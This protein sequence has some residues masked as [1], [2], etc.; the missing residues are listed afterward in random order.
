MILHLNFDPSECETCRHRFGRCQ[1]HDLESPLSMG[2]FSRACVEYLRTHEHLRKK[3]H[4]NDP[5]NPGVKI[6]AYTIV[7]NGV[8]LSS[9]LRGQVGHYLHI[10]V[11][12]GSHG[13]E[14]RYERSLPA[15]FK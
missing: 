11:G 10:V 8:L 15:Y 13:R 9:Y 14:D 2:V 3:P 12:R 4:V 7:C 1:C 6:S 5:L